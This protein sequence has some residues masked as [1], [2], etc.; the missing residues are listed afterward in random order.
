MLWARGELK[1][2]P[3]HDRERGGEE[4]TGSRRLFGRT[5]P[6]PRREEF[7]QV[8]RLREEAKNIYNFTVAVGICSLQR[9][10]SNVRLI[11]WL[12]CLSV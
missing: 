10:C 6:L 9:G 4:K 3:N 8:V 7:R 5:L 1:A 11:T 12:G 2:V